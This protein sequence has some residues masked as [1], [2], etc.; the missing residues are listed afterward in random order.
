MVRMLLDAKAS[1]FLVNNL[2]N[3]A[4]HVAIAMRR[5]DIAQIL[6]SFG[7]PIH[8][9]NDDGDTPL[10]KAV[11]YRDWH[12]V[13]FL[14]DSGLTVIDDS[15]PKMVHQLADSRAKCKAVYLCMVGVM[16]KRLL[17]GGHIQMVP[18]M[19]KVLAAH[20]WASR[21]DTHVWNQKKKKK[22]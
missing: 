17:F 1:P 12:A 22:K 2:G 11:L 19:V 13:C 21:F 20:V 14:L 7:A 8:C 3:T 5:L 9:M 15:V 18:D 6:L 16:R 10:S 4:L